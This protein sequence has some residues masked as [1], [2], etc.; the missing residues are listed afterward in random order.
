MDPLDVEVRITRTS[1]KEQ[2][3]G[4][5]RVLHIPTQRY[6]PFLVDS[7][8]EQKQVL[9][10]LVELSKLVVAY[11]NRSADDAQGQS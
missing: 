4:H 1:A 3:R 5:G 6:I 2:W 11:E 8:N 9:E 7:M 10:A